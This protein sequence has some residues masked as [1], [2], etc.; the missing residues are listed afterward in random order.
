[1]LTRATIWVNLKDIIV[2]E[3]SQSL[4]D[5]YYTRSHLYEVLRIVKIIKIKSRM[6]VAR[7]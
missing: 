2:N 3:I 1:M 7:G 6:M 4:R 5:K